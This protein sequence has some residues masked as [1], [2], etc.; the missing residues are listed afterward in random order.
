MLKGV[1]K[2]MIWGTTILRGMLGVWVIAQIRL[3]NDTQ[4]D[5]SRNMGVNGDMKLVEKEHV[6]LVLPDLG[7]YI[8]STFWGGGGGR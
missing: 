2:G 5:I 7:V 3:Y 1:I 4:K 8:V 6:R